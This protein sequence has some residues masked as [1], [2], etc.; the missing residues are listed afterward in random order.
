MRS[1]NGVRAHACQSK[2]ARRFIR[3]DEYTE[4]TKNVADGGKTEKRIGTIGSRNENSSI[5]LTER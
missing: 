4:W 2:I 3:R 5:P 1:G